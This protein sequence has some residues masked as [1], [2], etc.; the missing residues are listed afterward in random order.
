MKR[1]R[2]GRSRMKMIQGEEDIGKKETTA[3]PLGTEPALSFLSLA[4]H[5]YETGVNV[6]LLSW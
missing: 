1:V 5:L 4:T 3:L 2:A 6:N